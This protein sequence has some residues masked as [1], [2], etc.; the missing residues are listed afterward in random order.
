MDGH[1]NRW[2]GALRVLNVDTTGVAYPQAMRTPAWAD[3]M[4][5]TQLASWT[6]LRH[7]NILYV[8][9]SFSSNLCQYPAGYVEPYP[10]FYAA[11]GDYAR[12]GQ[13]L[14]KNLDSAAL[15]AGEVRIRQTA[16]THFG[17]L[18][19]VADQLQTLAE[20]ELRLEPFSPE[21]EA[22]LKQIA[23]YR[24]NSFY[25]P[26]WTGWYPEL[27]LESGTGF[28]VARKDK[29][30]ALIADIHTNPG[31]GLLH[32][33]SVLHVAT[34]PVAVIIFIADTDEGP[35]MYVGPVFTY[36]EVVTTGFLFTRLTDEDWRRQLSTGSY[37]AAPAWTGSFR[38]PASGSPGYLEIH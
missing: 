23:V 34:G 29:S 16:M 30:P 4:L 9:Q 13:R 8:K 33:P 19:T 6:Q 26:Q 38:V 35:T 5:H 11:I 36:F 31:D 18:A 21:E 10:E 7:D 14:I 3:K 2:L 28:Q 24:P 32:P 20:K 25:S 12:A 27:F 17:H 22:F 37:P 1:Y 15:T